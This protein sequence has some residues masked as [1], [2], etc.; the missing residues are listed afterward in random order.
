MKNK[1]LSNKVLNSLNVTE[2]KLFD[3]LI[4]NHQ[5]L[6]NKMIVVQ[7]AYTDA[8]RSGKVKDALLRK[9]ADKGFKAEYNT[10]E[11]LKKLQNFIKTVNNKYT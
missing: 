6:Q 4:K 7:R 9:M 10:F 3:K 1:L 2:K 8:L 11:A 5:D